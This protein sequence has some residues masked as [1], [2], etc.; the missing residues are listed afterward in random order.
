MRGSFLVLASS[1]ILLASCS[2]PDTFH[3][4]TGTWKLYAFEVPDEG[5][6]FLKPHHIVRDILITCEDRGK[7]GKYTAQTITNVVEGKYEIL[8]NGQIMFTS[9]DGT[10]FGEPEWGEE[11][12]EGLMNAE[13]YEIQPEQLFLYFNDGKTRMSFEKR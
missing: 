10:L 13:S 6:V 7:K 2:K 8:E 5:T 11:F 1:L 9:M 4:L 3:T 12:R